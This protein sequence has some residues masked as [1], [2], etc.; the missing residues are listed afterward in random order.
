MSSEELKPD[1]E[2]LHLFVR[3]ATVFTFVGA[4]TTFFICKLV[5]L[6]EDLATRCASGWLVILGG[7]SLTAS[8]W[9]KETYVV[10]KRLIRFDEMPFSFSLTIFRDVLLVLFG[11]FFSLRI[12]D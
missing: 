7:V 4:C 9:T 5:Y 10:H 3:R 1:H 6:D 8:F 2:S 12:L 11:F